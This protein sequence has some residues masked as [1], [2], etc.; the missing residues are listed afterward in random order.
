MQ[1]VEHT[2][3]FSSLL[4]NIADLLTLRILRLFRI[5]P[6]YCY[7]CEGSRFYLRRIRRN[8]PSFNRHNS[9][10]TFDHASASTLP[11][12]EPL[13]QESV[14]NYLRDEQ[15]LLMR[16][17]RATRYSQK[18]RDATVSRVLAEPASLQ[19]ISQELNVT[20]SDVLD[21]I[22]DYVNR[23]Q[24][25]IRE[26]QRRLRS[27]DRNLSATTGEEVVDSPAEIVLDKNGEQVIDGRVLPQ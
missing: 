22:S 20:A 5:G 25:T 19:R 1:N 10:V 11:E 26:L 14:G 15:S 23:Q 16:E 4:L 3:K 13:T 27:F 17:Q 2:R 12:S 7:Q 8:F 24:Q 6:W 18:Y 21:W 9:Q